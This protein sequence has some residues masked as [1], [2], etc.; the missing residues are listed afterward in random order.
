MH[1]HTTQ[2]VAKIELM[3]IYTHDVFHAIELKL[4]LQLAHLGGRLEAQSTT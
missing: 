1:A 2:I 4:R 3:L